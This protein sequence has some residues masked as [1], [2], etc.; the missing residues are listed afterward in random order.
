MTLVYY[1]IYKPNKIV[2][3]FQIHSLLQRKQ[4]FQCQVL[5]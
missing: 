5:A 4:I 1:I 2:I 3:V